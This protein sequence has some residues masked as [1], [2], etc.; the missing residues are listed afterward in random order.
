MKWNVLL[1][2]ELRKKVMALCWFSLVLSTY[3]EAGER[4]QKTVQV[5]E[6]TST[7]VA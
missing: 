7:W 2:K 4:K 6:L 1:S 3:E 5:P